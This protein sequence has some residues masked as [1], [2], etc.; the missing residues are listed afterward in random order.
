MGRCCLLWVDEHLVCLAEDGTLRLVRARPES[1][2]VVATA[3]IRERRQQGG[4][5]EGTSRPLIR[6]PAWSAPVLA[7]GLLYLRGKD[8]LV[9]LELIPSGSSRRS[10]ARIFQPP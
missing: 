6:Y 2:E 9:C 3:T 10:L 4:G 7:H 1:Y 5:G 8:R